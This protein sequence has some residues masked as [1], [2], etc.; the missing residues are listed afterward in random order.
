MPDHSW[1]ITGT[2]A[3]KK[4]DKSAFLHRGSGIP[5]DTR[6]FFSVED[7][8]VGQKLNISLTVGD[9]TYSAYLEMNRSQRTRMFWSNDFSK[10]LRNKFSVYYN[11]LL[12]G[13]VPENS[14]ITLILE[15]KND[16]L[17]EVRFNR[18]KEASITISARKSILDAYA[19]ELEN[20]NTRYFIFDT[21]GGG[22]EHEDIDFLSYSWSPKIF[23]RVR[24][25]DLIIYRRPTKASENNKFYFFGA[26]KI[27]SITQ[28]SPEHLKARIS[29]PLP[30]SMRLFQEDLND[31]DWNFRERG[32]TWERFF[33]QYG[34]TTITKS[35]FVGLIYLAF[36]EEEEIEESITNANAEAQLIQQQLTGDFSVE[37]SVGLQKRRIGHK[38]FAD[39]V[40][41]YYDY[42]CAISGIKAKD[43]LV[44]S[45]IIPWS[46]RK[47]SRLDPSNGIC[48]SVFFDKAFDKGYI[49]LTT[50][51]KVKV[52]E[53]CDP[54]I[55]TILAQYK[56]KRI[57]F[58]KAAPPKHA[59]LTW[60]NENIFERFLI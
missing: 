5:V 13:S 39:K 49:T 28:L 16:N 9:R 58:P 26:G 23:N 55:A 44:A 52:S 29:N 40:K 7:L 48:L 25:G 50:D 27:E 56:N 1:T 31:F 42:T 41:L 37:D 53:N 57:A 14:G 51:Y 54:T 10:L 3:T 60:H 18:D 17:Y 11:N 43:F 8:A 4:L 20:I 33:N 2:V 45:H 59:Y 30:F 38:V 32:P 47:E 24:V 35:D 21:H 36:N 15:R 46:E 6:H 22:N 34:M 19:P 12:S